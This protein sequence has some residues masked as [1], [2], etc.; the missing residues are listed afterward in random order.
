MGEG[1]YYTKRQVSEVNM[2]M[3]YD[4]F[5]KTMSLVFAFLIAQPS[6]I[7]LDLYTSVN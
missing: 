1:L 7:K 4:A 5:L 3:I 6:E 2:I